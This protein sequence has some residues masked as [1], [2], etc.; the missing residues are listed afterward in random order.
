MATQLATLLLRRLEVPVVLTDVDAERAAAAVESIRGELAALVAKGRLTEGKARFLGS[1]VRAGDGLD[2]YEGCDL[3]LEAVFEEL[4]VKREVF[5]GLEDVVAPECLLVTNT[6][7]LSV[8]SM[9]RDS[10][11]PSGSSGST[12][13]TPSRCCRSSRSCA[14]RRPTTRPSS[15]PGT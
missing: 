11:I 8:T 14:P 6:S 15:P 9:E 3:V 10:A 4:G 2:A 1:I 5:R 12:S 13:S 7:A